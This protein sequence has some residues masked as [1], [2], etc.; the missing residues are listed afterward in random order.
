MSN[1]LKKDSPIL[2]I[3]IFDNNKK[4]MVSLLRDCGYEE[5]RKIGYVNYIFIRR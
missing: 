5:K 1:L 3:E 2:W 4:E